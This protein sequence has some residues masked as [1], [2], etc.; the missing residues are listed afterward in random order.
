MIINI[1]LVFKEGMFNFGSLYLQVVIQSFYA[2]NSLLSYGFVSSG[3]FNFRTF[4]TFGQPQPN[5]AK[6]LAEAKVALKTEE[7]CLFCFLFV[8]FVSNH[9]NP[10]SRP[11][12]KLKFGMPATIDPTRRNKQNNFWIKDEKIRSCS[13]LPEMAR[14]QV[15][16]QL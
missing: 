14:K 12:R 2:W 5:S 16:L 10:T 7:I 3:P 1:Q 4:I 15:N 9:R 6:L 13:K 8:L 11:S